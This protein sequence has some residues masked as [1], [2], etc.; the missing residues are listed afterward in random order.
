MPVASISDQLRRDEGCR[1]RPYKDTVGKLTIGVGRNLD[2]VGISQSE[3][4]L[5]LANDINHVTNSLLAQWPWMASLD[6]VRFGVMQ[7]MAFNMGIGGLAAF[8]NTL[9]KV[10]SGDY[11]GAA[12]EM[13]HSTWATQVGDRAQRLSIQLEGG[14][15]Q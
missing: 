3:A 14:S 12:E 15:W 1:L 2:D 8:K 5:L 13:L 9:A 11:A 6:E 4:D 7:N 10:K